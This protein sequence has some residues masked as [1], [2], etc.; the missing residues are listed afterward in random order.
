MNNEN[1]NGAPAENPNY[2]AWAEIMNNPPRTAE[3]EQP[4]SPVE[5]SVPA[6]AEAPESQPDVT[7]EGAEASNI[8]QQE[9]ELVRAT[10]NDPAENGEIL[11]DL[12][13]FRKSM[14][15]EV[16]GQAQDA[17]EMARAEQMN[18]VMSTAIE[19][20]KLV[21]ELAGVSVSSALKRLRTSYQER[22][23]QAETPGDIQ[24][25]TEGENAVK[26]L[27]FR[28]HNIVAEKTAAN[29]GTT[30]DIEMR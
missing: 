16:M 21:S 3:A 13:G 5:Q 22:V 15:S 4:V 11:Q 24:I 14:V 9:E 23:A 19:S 27:I 28:S 30:P 17:G 12:D 7:L 20:A 29:A 25:F 2:Q 10:E 6:K 26:Q 18:L 8:A 1:L